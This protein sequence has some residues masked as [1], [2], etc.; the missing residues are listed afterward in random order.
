MI[1]II[2]NYD[3]FVYNLAQYIGE[4]GREP[5][6][7]RNDSV[8]IDEI[9][10]MNPSVNY[11]LQK[12][13]PES[14]KILAEYRHNHVFDQIKLNMIEGIKQGLYRDDLN[15]DLISTFYLFRTEKAMDDNF[16][17]MKDYSFEEIFNTM[18]IYH[19]RAIANEKDLNIWMKKLKTKN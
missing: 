18:F 14:W 10:E 11:D 1:L 13:H 5:L 4:L 3:S 15:I 8:T 12:Y 19:I 6:V 7:C 9:K 2:D 17:Q 16:F